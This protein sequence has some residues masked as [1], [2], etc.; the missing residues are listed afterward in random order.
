MKLEKE[1]QTLAFAFKGHAGRI[2]IQHM[3]TYAV[4]AF[5]NSGQQ[6]RTCKGNL[7]NHF[8]TR[9]KFF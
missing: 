8:T 4:L 5:N 1:G 6:R 7:Q 9:V 2:L 3:V